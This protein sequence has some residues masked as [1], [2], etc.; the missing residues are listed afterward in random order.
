MI[1]E[2]K[3]GMRRI[4]ILLIVAIMGCVFVAS[5]GF[6]ADK[7]YSGF[8]GDLYK[9]LQPGPK[10]GAKERWLKPGVMF[11]KYNKFIIHPVTFF[12]AEESEYKGIDPNE[13]KELADAFNQAIGAAFKDKYP[14]TIAP[15]PDV[16]RLCIAV[17][18]LK[19]SK[20]AL[21]AVTSIVPVGLAV[22]A[23]K[24]GSTGAWSGSGTTSAELV[25]LDSL[26]HEPI[27]AAVDERSAAFGDRFSKW[28][29]AQE[30]FKFWAERMV[31]FID[32]TRGMKW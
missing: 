30:A 11:G 4:R 1:Q 22:S 26:T 28:E 7:K 31:S 12:F 6:A 20:P 27:L 23:A 14:L 13:M 24:K 9:N 8:L 18:G 15:G 16:A 3:V 2:G 5:T 29:S 21:S 32:D 17:T 25:L 19:A 10:D